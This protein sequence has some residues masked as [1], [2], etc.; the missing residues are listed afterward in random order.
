MRLLLPLL[1]FL[2]LSPAHAKTVFCKVEKSDLGAPTYVTWDD[3]TKVA[4]ISY[5]VDGTLVGKLTLISR[6]GSGNEAVNLSFTS[7]PKP[8][9]DS[10]WEFIV[11]EPFKGKFVVLGAGYKIV[12]GVKYLNSWRGLYDAKCD[13]L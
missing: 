13:S 8:W 10:E 7:V 5:P 1:A 12:G 4:K 3:T 6:G 2:V 11:H 9:D